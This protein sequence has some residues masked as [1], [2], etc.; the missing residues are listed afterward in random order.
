M[1]FIGELIIGFIL[2]ILKG[3]LEWLLDKTYYA[4]RA[5][6]MKHA[7]KPAPPN[8]SPKIINYYRH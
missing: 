4:W 7:K 1:S 5:K 2:E 6:R 8:A 3:C